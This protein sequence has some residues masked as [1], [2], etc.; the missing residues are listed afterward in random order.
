MQTA[1]VSSGHERQDVQGRSEE[2]KPNLQAGIFLIDLFTFRKC[3]KI[4]HK[5]VMRHPGISA[6]RG[7]AQDVMAKCPEAP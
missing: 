4:L 6:R 1:S 2:A 5:G 3:S 7:T